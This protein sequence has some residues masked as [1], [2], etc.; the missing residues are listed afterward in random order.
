MLFLTYYIVI[1][2]TS[3]MSRKP[4]NILHVDFVKT[5]FSTSLCLYIDIILI[6]ISEWFGLF[7]FVCVRSLVFLF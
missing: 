4:Y 2:R 5:W 7:F 6:L 3:D 1:L